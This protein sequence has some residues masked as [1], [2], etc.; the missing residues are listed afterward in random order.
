MSKSVLHLLSQRPLL[1]GSGMTLDALV[2]EAARSG[3]N[4]RIVVGLPA[5]EENTGVGGLPSEACLPLYFETSELPFPVPG[6]SDVMPYRSTVFSQMDKAAIAQYESA[7]RRHL[8]DVVRHSRP[9]LIHVHHIWWLAAL[10]KDVAPDVPVVNHCHATGLRQIELCPQFKTQIV[11]GVRRN[12]RFVCLH[13]QDAQKLIRILDIDAGRVDV[14]GAG[15]RQN[16]FGT[17]S[18]YEA[19]RSK[20]PTILYAGKFSDAKGLPWLLDAFERLLETRPEARLHLAGSGTGPEAEKII[21]R[22]QGMHETVLW[23][24]HIEA[25]KLASLMRASSVFVL[26]SFYEGL[27]LVLVE[28]IACGCTVV[29]TGLPG[30]MDSLYPS[31][32]E[33]MHILKPPPLENVDQPVSGFGEAFT[34]EI[35]K[36]LMA[37]LDSSGE[38]VVPPSASLQPFT[39]SAVF[40]R[41]ES[42]WEKLLKRADA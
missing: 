28:A 7:W 30:V 41:V 12:E 42:V 35:R 11:T 6:M 2:R 1:T 36:A 19:E 31:L 23:H 37:A 25:D 27:P 20:S 10:V 22:V 16:I 40:S 4:Q 21:E 29:A 14:V 13:R 18:D 39:W 9:D 33:R 26:P 38:M 32:K 15:Y 8:E 3:W 24:G 34:E 5:G 17:A